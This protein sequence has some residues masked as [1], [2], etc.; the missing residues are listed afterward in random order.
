MDQTITQ[1]RFHEIILLKSINPHFS[2]TYANK[3]IIARNTSSRTKNH[4]AISITVFCN[5]STVANNAIVNELN[6]SVVY[7]EIMI[8]E[9]LHKISKIQAYN[10]IVQNTIIHQD[11][12]N[13]IEKIEVSQ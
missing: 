4:H 13:K 5:D 10:W 11:R 8:E 1:T 9:I 7:N 12:A 2:W 3:Y 6:I